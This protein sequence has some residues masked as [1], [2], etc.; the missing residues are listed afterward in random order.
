MGQG[1]SGKVGSGLWDGSGDGRW[2][3][4]CGVKWRGPRIEPR[5]NGVRCNP[6]ELTRP[7]KQRQGLHSAPAPLE[8][9][10][11]RHPSP[12]LATDP[13]CCGGGPE[14]T[15]GWS[16]GLARCSKAH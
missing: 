8:E 13:G 14:A 9:C 2:A 6:L 3:Y 10:W 5:L 4:N 7:R 11:V 12:L 16:L 1:W 15:Q